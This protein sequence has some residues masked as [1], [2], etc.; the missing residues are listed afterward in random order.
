MISLVLPVPPSA[1]RYWRKTNRGQVYVS[2]EAIAYKRDVAMLCRS[3]RLAALE[4]PVSL[5]MRFFRARRSGDLDNRTKVLLDSLQGHLYANDSQIRELH[6]YLG[7]D[8]K[9]PR[10][11]VE[12]KPMEGV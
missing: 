7:D 5:T 1:N 12:I 6:C 3:E 11:E 2:P 8:A 9:N 4:G 10:V